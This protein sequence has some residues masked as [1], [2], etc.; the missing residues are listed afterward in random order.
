MVCQPL[1]VLSQP[2]GVEPLDRLNDLGVERRATR[3]EQT[4]VRHVVSQAVL[5]RVSKLRVEARF[6]QKLGGLESAEVSSKGVIRPVGDDRQDGV[7][8][9]LADDRGGLEELLLLGRQAIDPGRQHRLRRR[10]D[11]NGAE[12]AGQAVGATIAGQQSDLDQ[13]SDAL[14]KEEWVPVGS[15]DQECFQVTERSVIASDSRQQ[16]IGALGRQRINLELGVVGLATPAVA[17]LRSVVDQQ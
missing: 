15:V 10:R 13:R 8:H 6:V 16:V 9:V 4:A 11:L 2:V 17:V 3:L 7:R 5:E 12:R 1:D 14:F